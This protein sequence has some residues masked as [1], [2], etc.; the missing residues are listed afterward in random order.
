[1][2]SPRSCRQSPRITVALA[3]ALMGVH[4]L[5]K[6]RIEN[7]GYDGWWS[8]VGMLGSRA[9]KAR[10]ANPSGQPGTAILP[11]SGGG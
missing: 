4:T 7:S 9:V 10:D 3:A 8:D 1:M 6:C 5:G 2:K 11:R